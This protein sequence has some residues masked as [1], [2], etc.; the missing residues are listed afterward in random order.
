[1]WK[2]SPWNWFSMHICKVFSIRIAYFWYFISIWSNFLVQMAKIINWVGIYVLLAEM[3]QK[4]HKTNYT[5]SPESRLPPSFFQKNQENT[6]FLVM[7]CTIQ[8]R[9][10]SFCTYSRLKCVNIICEFF[11]QVLSCLI[12]DACVCVR[13]DI[14]LHT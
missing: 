13:S 6:I 11:R 2:F 3:M 10:L 7:Y 12:T 8:E 4:I 14:L 5:D 1:M 9:C